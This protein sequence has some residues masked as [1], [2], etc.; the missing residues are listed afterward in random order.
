MKALLFDVDGTLYRDRVLRWIMARRLAR[1]YWSQPAEG[2]RVLRVLQAYRRGQ[3]HLRSAADAELELS[4]QQLRF[5]VWQTGEAIETVRAYVAR[6]MEQEPIAHLR[7][8]MW[9]GVAE[10]LRLAKYRGWLLGAVSD[11]PART[12]LAV[13]GIAD[14]FDTVV[15]AQDPAVQSFKPD[16][17]GLEFALKGLGV[18]RAQAIYV[19]DRPEV[20]A[21]AAFRAGIPCVIVGRKRSAGPDPFMA[22]PDFAALATALTM[23]FKPNAD[24]KRELAVVGS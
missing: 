17:R 1:C 8:A 21:V 4:E 24:L 11:Y 18:P 3:E 15:C 19:G 12:K 7:A 16:P 10:T 14:L 20:D 6:W 22:I 23:D 5:A 13:L 2:F 9:P